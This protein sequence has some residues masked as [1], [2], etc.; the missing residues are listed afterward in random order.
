MLKITVPTPTTLFGAAAR[1][2][3]KF[4]ELPLAL[5]RKTSWSGSRHGVCE[6]QLLPVSSSQRL[7]AV[8]HLTISPVGGAPGVAPGGAGG[9]PPF[10]LTVPSKSDV[11]RL[12]E[13]NTAANT[14]APFDETASARGVSPASCTI[15]SGVPP[16]AA[17]RLLA[18]NAHT[19]ARPTPGVVSC[20]PWSG[21]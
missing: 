20:G 17:P 3:T 11:V 8:F 6:F 2:G 21:P 19:S 4:G 1:T 16:S 13:R 15:E 7:V 5:M 9:R 12:P 18:S 14:V 10:P